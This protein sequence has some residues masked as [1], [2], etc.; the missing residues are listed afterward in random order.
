MEYWFLI[1]RWYAS[2]LVTYI[3]YGE[4]NDLPRKD[5]GQ[6][7]RALDA[8]PGAATP[9]NRSSCSAGSGG[10]WRVRSGSRTMPR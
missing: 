10:F 8:G 4:T 6:L 5:G 1:L 3:S 9:A 7:H 2:S